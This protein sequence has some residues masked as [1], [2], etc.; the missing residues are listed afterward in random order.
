MLVR[1]REVSRSYGATRAL[2]RVSLEVAAGEVHAV[3]GAN[4]AG[5]STLIGVISGAERDF[6]G[7]LA[8]DGVPRRLRGTADA[9]RAG[10][11]TIFQELSLIGPM[12]VEDNLLLGRGAGALSWLRR[13]RRAEAERLLAE[14]GLAVDPAAPVESLSLALRQRIEIARALGRKARLLVMD[15]PTSALGESDSAE[16]LARIESLR[17]GGTA[18]VFISHRL[19]EIERLADRIT[20]LRDGRVV[21]TAKRGELDR[22]RL[23]EWIAGRALETPS[24]ARREGQAR[25]DELFEAHQLRLPDPDR[26]DRILLDGIDLAVHR[27]EIVGLAGLAASGAAELV[28]ALGGGLPMSGSASLEGSALS[29]TPPELIARGVVWIGGDRSRA[30]VGTLS[31]SSLSSLSSLARFSRFGWIRRAEERREVANTVARL[32]L[33]ARS[34]DAP[35]A[36][37]SGGNQQKV[38]F[39][40]A[41][42]A[43]PRLLLLDDPTRGIDIGAKSEIH[44]LLR[45]L[46]ASG[47]GLL[48]Y[49][50]ELDELCAC[51]RVIVLARGRA[52]AELARTELSRARILEAAMGGRA[53]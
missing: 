3:A 10:I 19:D 12:S 17:D 26:P 50:P 35:V 27:G 31:V 39:A 20:I 37:L 51:D 6:S 41:L 25:G 5:K 29:L 11:A 22:Q 28:R 49:S 44:A 42:L 16:L 13:D 9:A 1:L 38:A 18:I 21:T 2:D 32:R 46:A 34:L 23:I 45:E 36:E 30:V 33:V 52:V 24:P 43:R 40:R 7:T 8:I 15:E 14:A 4:G 47:V 53:A 48:L